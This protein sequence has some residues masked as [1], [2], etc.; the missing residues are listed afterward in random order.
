[1]HVDLIIKDMCAIPILL[2]STF[3]FF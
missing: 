2:L 1:M 3:P